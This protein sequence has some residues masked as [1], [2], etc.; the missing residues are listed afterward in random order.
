MPRAT[1]YDRLQRAKKPDKYRKIKQFIRKTFFASGQSYGYRRIHQKAVEAGF[2]L[3]E[4]TIRKIMTVMGLKVTLYSKHTGRYNSYKG[5]V[6]KVAPN[7]LNQTFNATKPL[8]VMH[9]DITQVALT[10]GKWGYISAVI[11][12]ASKE[13]LTVLASYSPNKALIKKTLDKLE[14]RINPELKPILHSD[15]GWQYQV[16]EYRDRLKDLGIVQSMSRKGNCHDNAPAESFFSILKRECLK[17]YQ[18]KNI[19]E[20]RAIL[21]SYIKWYNH[22]RISMGTKGLSP[23]VYSNKVLSV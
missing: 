6:G 3:C 17:R 18:I 14:P 4:E 16:S 15:Q 10:N 23:V 7:L 12:E 11:D 22:K 20:L 19:T 2:T 5:S 8:T 21:A 1:Y 13:A 9:T